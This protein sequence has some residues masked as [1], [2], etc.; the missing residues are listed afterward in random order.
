MKILIVDIET[1]DF[2]K[3]NGKIVEVGMVSLDLNTGKKEIVF[4]SVCHEKPITEKEIENSW[5]VKNSDL[6]KKAILDSP[7]FVDIKHKIQGIINRYPDGITAYNNAFDFQ[8]LESRGI[9][10]EKKLPC[11]MIISTPIVKINNP[12]DWGDLYKW[13][14]VEEAY[15]HF[16]PKTDFIE[17]HRGGDDAYHEADIVLKLYQIGKF[18]VH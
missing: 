5:I 3:N 10:L 14:S 7:E 17:K 11:P 9:N 4:N 12:Y 1:T 8:F 13:P 6:T 16:F 18:K 2:F 15:Y